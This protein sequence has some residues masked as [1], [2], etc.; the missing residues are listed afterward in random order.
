MA[1]TNEIRS[2]L[3][4]RAIVVEHVLDGFVETN[5]TDLRCHGH[6]ALDVALTQPQQALRIAFFR[7]P[8]ALL[9]APPVLVVPNPPHLTSLI[10][11]SHCRLLPHE[12]AKA[13]ALS[14]GR[15]CR[16]IES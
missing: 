16:A 4:I 13:S 6:T 8:R 14:A 12:A 2:W 3:P 11:F 10:E 5:A 9:V 15:P 1:A 7:A